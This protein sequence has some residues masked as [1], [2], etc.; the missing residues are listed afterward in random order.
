MRDLGGQ[1][2]DC[3]RFTVISSR[4]CARCTSEST[5][6]GRQS[7]ERDRH[8]SARYTATRAAQE[9]RDQRTALASTACAHRATPVDRR[10]AT[11]Q[12]RKS[13][14]WSRPN[15][16]VVSLHSHVLPCQLAARVNVRQRDVKTG[17]REER[18]GR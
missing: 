8:D 5:S 15:A 3:V 14:T 11:T 7:S 9:S 16:P 17:W 12:W 6:Q 18:Y 10:S 4:V 2:A 13:S 1:G